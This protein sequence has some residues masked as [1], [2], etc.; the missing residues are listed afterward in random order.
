MYLILKLVCVQIQETASLKSNY[1]DVS[2]ELISLI[3]THCADPQ[4]N[5]L[6]SF[7]CLHAAL[8][9]AMS[10]IIGI[11]FCASFIQTLVEQLDKDRAF[12]LENHSSEEVISKKCANLTTLL[13][14]CCNFGVISC[15]LLYD[16]IKQSIQS[17]FI[18]VDVDILLRILK[19][20]I[21]PTKKYQEVI[22]ELKIRHL[23]K[24]LYY[25]CNQK[26][27]KLP[28]HHHRDANLCLN[29]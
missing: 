4:L 27:R 29:L 8:V 10:F 16:I 13:S 2:S 14:F 20:M 5:M 22:L 6:D 25:W 9:S 18:E 15:K 21:L 28:L 24:K 7:S 17:G 19:G 23:S 3:I 11:D 26:L 12:V 1:V